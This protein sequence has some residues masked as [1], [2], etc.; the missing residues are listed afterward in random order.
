MPL[1]H[2]RNWYKS[3]YHG[4]QV[5]SLLGQLLM[6]KSEQEGEDAQF[7]QKKNPGTS[8]NRSAGRSGPGKPEPQPL[9]TQAPKP[10]ARPGL[11]CAT[12]HRIK[13]LRSSAPEG[14]KTSM[15]RNRQ[16]L[17]ED[18]IS[19]ARVLLNKQSQGAPDTSPQTRGLVGKVRTQEALK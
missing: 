8:Y 12:K 14:T 17:H 5:C 9:A 10:S 18:S 15:A 6:L 13:G 7:R 16:W 19:I 3:L 4:F 11:L 1:N 2:V